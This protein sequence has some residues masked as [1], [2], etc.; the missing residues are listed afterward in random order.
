MRDSST[1]DDAVH[2]CRCIRRHVP[3]DRHVVVAPCGGIEHSAHPRLRVRILRHENP[4]CL[5]TS[6]VL[7]ARTVCT[8]AVAGASTRHDDARERVLAAQ[9]VVER[10]ADEGDAHSLASLDCGRRVETD[11]PCGKEEDGRGAV[12]SI[13]RHVDRGWPS[14]LTLPKAVPAGG[15]SRLGRSAVWTMRSVKSTGGRSDLGIVPFARLSARRSSSW[16][17]LWRRE[18]GR[19]AVRSTCMQVVGEA[20]Q[21][22]DVLHSGAFSG[23]R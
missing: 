19:G 22:V 5:R 3:T 2:T 15:S 17:Y 9:V 18:E 10:T 1:V 11:V 8:G 21:L 6:A 13:C 16:M 7:G 20:V 4:T 12:V 14:R 23:T